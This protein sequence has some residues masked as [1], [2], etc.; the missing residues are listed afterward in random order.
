MKSNKSKVY[1][2]TMYRYCNRENHSYVLGVFSTKT[3]AEKAG[4]EERENRGGTKYYPECL[5]V[6]IDKVPDEHFRAIVPLEIH[7]N[8]Y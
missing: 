4:E 8:F 7:T 2:V 1:V 5:E 6:P 3:K